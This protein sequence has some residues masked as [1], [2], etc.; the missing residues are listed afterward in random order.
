MAEHASPQLCCHDVTRCNAS[1]KANVPTTSADDYM[2]QLP[3]QQM[4]YMG[5]QPAPPPVPAA[6]APPPGGMVPYYNPYQQFRRLGASDTKIDKINADV[7][8]SSAC[9]IPTHNYA[10]VALVLLQSISTDAE[11]I[12]EWA[13]LNSGATSHFLTTTATA[14]NILL[15]VVPLVA[16]LPND[17]RVSSTHTC[18]L[19]LLSL[20]S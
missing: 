11:T 9:P 8:F 2:G 20:L 19:D 13:I 5:Q 17:E 15:A 7:N 14:T 1:T 6:M 3:Q 4:N 16:C 10:Y 18:T 12:K